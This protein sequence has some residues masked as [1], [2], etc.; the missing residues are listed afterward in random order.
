MNIGLIIG[1]VAGFTVLMFAVLVAGGSLLMFFDLP[2]MLVT[3]GGGWSAL[4]VA[5]PIS[6]LMKMP[7]YIRIAVFPP[8][9]DHVELIITLVQFSEKSRREGLLS[10]EDDIEA[11]D[12]EF[13]KKALQLLVD[14]TDPE[15]VKTILEVDID[16]MAMRHDANKKIFDDF[17]GLA[18]S[19]G[20]IGTLMGLVLMLVNLNDRAMVGPYLA[21]AIITTFYGA[22][23]AYLVLTPLAANLDTLTGEEVL[24]KSILVMGVLSIQAG[25]NPRVLK[26]KLASFLSPDMRLSLSDEKGE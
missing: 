4:M 25:D 21:V 16:Q 11:I 6:A 5:Y 22:V 19:F 2:A 20:M 24:Y 15:L 3:F 18:P 17:A 8:K 7:T 9:L 1:L 10:L 13:L 23:L 26:E 14:G 12:D